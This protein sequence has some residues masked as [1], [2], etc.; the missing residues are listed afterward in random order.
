MGKKQNEMFLIKTV[1]ERCY[2]TT[3][4]RKKNFRPKQKGK[5]TL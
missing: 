5:K 4:E 3:E 2:Q 1:S